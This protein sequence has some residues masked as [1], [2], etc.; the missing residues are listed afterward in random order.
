MAAAW[1]MR[2]R[3]AR[4]PIQWPICP[5][6]ENVRDV[7]RQRHRS[8]RSAAGTGTTVA[9]RRLVGIPGSPTISSAPAGFRIDRLTDAKPVAG[10]RD[11]DPDAFDK[12]NKQPTVMVI[13]ATRPGLLLQG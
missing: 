12:Y 4:L 11:V 6:H 7:T 2:S 1:P 10:L 13:E 8:A 9:L 5:L 3:G